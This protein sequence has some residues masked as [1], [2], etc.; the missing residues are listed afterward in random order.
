MIVMEITR[1][2]PTKTEVELEEMAS[3]IPSIIFPTSSLMSSTA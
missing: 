2:L 1:S 3:D